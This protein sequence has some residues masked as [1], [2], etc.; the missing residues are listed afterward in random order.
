MYGVRRL[1]CTVSYDMDARVMS[2][3]GNRYAQVSA[4]KFF[5]IEAYPIQKKIDC[6]LGLTLFAIHYGAPKLLI[7]D[8]SPEQVGKK[9]IFQSLIRKYDIRTH[10][11]ESYRP[12]QNSAQDAIRNLRKKLFRD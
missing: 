12:S 8:R 4:T 11:T 7:H 1:N 2:L 3:N 9:T 6:H 5:F 10:V